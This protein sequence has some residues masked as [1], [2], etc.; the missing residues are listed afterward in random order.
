LLSATGGG[1]T[2]TGDLR[3]VVVVVGS[4]V[5]WSTDGTGRLSVSGRRGLAGVSWTAQ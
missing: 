1:A 2:G 5:F 4:G 3:T